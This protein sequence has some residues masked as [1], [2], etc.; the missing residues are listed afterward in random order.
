MFFIL[1]LFFISEKKLSITLK[2]SDYLA[3]LVDQAYVLVV[4]KAYAPVLR[5]KNERGIP[6]TRPAQTVYRDRNFQFQ[7][8][9]LSVAVRL[10]VLL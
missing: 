3:H 6:R 8:P 1:L 5:Y 10:S 4:G 7:H 9:E 2:E